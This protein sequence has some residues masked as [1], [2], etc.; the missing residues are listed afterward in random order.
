MNRQSMLLIIFLFLSHEAEALDRSCNALQAV[1]LGSKLDRMPAA[2]RDRYA[3]ELEQLRTQMDQLFEGWG[4]IERE[5]QT[6]TNTHLTAALEDNKRLVEK[7]RDAV[8]RERPDLVQSPEQFQLE[9]LARIQRDS[10]FAAD[11][12]RRL[13]ADSVYDGAA[14]KALLAQ[15][16]GHGLEQELYNSVLQAPLPAAE[17]APKI[18]TL[19][20][21]HLAAQPALREG[22]YAGGVEGE[23]FRELAASFAAVS[24]G[25]QGSLQKQGMEFAVSQSGKVFDTPGDP[26]VVATEELRSVQRG[27]ESMRLRAELE[28]SGDHLGGYV[29][30]PGQRDKLM[31][32]NSNLKKAIVQTASLAIQERVNVRQGYDR[33]QKIEVPAPEPTPSEAPVSWAEKVKD[34]VEK[35]TAPIKKYILRKK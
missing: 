25:K 5:Y 22:V 17:Y 28:F 3:P 4:G 33:L 1:R 23:A 19:A 21:S 16:E 11:L 13:R 6:V 27:L 34:E 24:A 15:S 2:T 35:Q 18:D 8:Q 10:S 9:V 7:H 29:G 26:V 12:E 14:S 20:N 31:H 30:T 32:G